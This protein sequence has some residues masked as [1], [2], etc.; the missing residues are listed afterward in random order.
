[1]AALELA[2]DKPEADR[3]TPE[4][5]IR[6]SLVMPSAWEE[7]CAWANAAGTPA[8]GE[9]P[10]RPERPERD[11]GEGNGAGGSLPEPSSAI[12]SPIPT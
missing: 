11:V 6:F 7:A 5:F 8:A 4:D 2:G 9:G 12:A 10:D 1:M 3:Y